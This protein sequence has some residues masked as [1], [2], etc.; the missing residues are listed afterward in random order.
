M[1]LILN[2]FRLLCGS[3]FIV[4]GSLTST[5]SGLGFTHY[6]FVVFLP[7]II[8]EIL[9]FK[10]YIN[11]V[12]ILMALV[13][14]M[15]LI[16]K[17]T[18]DIYYLFES[19]KLS[20]PEHFFFDYRKLSM[21]IDNFPDTL[22]TFTKQTLAP[23]QTIVAIQEVKRIA[24]EKSNANARNGL[25]VLN[26][27]ELTPIYAEL[28][29]EPPKGLPLWFH[30]NVSLFPRE[31]ETLE[32]MLADNAFDVILIQGTHEG[33]TGTYRRFLSIINANRSY[34]LTLTVHDSPANATWPCYPNCHGEI[35]VFMKH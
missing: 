12:V 27:T 14:S 18:R 2:N 9:K 17:P 4:S 35:Y 34:T 25:K 23:Q 26:L 8:A 16:V 1:A 5:T 11:K 29:V 13:S 10:I 24:N 31:I 30:T 15:V 3:I 20:M 6:Y 19:I 21:P 33:L 22:S 7:I 28:G 32:N